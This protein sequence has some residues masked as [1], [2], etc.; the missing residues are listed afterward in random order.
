MR[1]EQSDT[2]AVEMELTVLRA[3]CAAPSALHLGE[4]SGYQWQDQEHRVVYECLRAA[5]PIAAVPLRERMATHATRMGHPD[6]DWPLYFTPPPA[7]TDL[8]KLIHLL[9]ATTK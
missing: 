9:K 3:L 2:S 1:S 4:L 7:V 6:V 8:S 5:H